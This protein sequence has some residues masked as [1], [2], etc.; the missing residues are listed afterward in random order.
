MH[1]VPD[2]DHLSLLASKGLDVKIFNNG[3]YL[4]AHPLY[5]NEKNSFQRME[6]AVARLNIHPLDPLLKEL[7][8]RFLAFDQRPP[9]SVASHLIPLSDQPLD[10]LWLYKLPPQ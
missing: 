7:G 5:G 3:V 10:S 1:F 2:L 6:T 9:E 8:I 4:E